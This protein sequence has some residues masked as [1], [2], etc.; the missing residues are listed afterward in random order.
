MR[1]IKSIFA[2]IVLV[3]SLAAC[4]GQELPVAPT[5]PITLT[6]T[7]SLSATGTPAPTATKT[8]TPKPTKNHKPTLTFTP[9]PT[10]N[11]T[12]IAARETANAAYDRS[13]KEKETQIAQ[14][15][16]TCADVNI[17]NNSISPDG[18][19]FAASCGYKSDQVLVVQTKDDTK[20][21]LDFQNF[22]NPNTP[23]DIWGALAPISW[24]ND[25]KYLYFSTTLGYDGGGDQCFSGIGGHYGLFRLALDTGKWSTLVPSADSFPGYEIEFSPAGDYYAITRRGVT[26]TNLTTGK[27]S[28]IA[29]SNVQGLLW[30]PDGKNLAFSTSK[31]GEY[32][33]ESSSVSIWNAETARAQILYKTEGVLL[34]PESWIDHSTL[35]FEGE[36]R[37]DFVSTYTIYDYDLAQ[38]RIISSGTPTPLALRSP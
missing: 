35:R 18:K 33:V 16:P 36:K 34:R 15:P 25:G 7:I 29:G 11:P 2:R 28:R 9:A 20:W 17:Y 21:T 32:L 5:N 19:W 24:S 30:S 8:I 27:T 37:I 12:A 4:S 13:Q 6:S 26:I 14:F 31:C 1:F 38:K 22:L 3:F 10:V 23:A